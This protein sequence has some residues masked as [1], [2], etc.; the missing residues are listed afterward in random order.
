M[1][2]TELKGRYWTKESWNEWDVKRQLFDFLTQWDLQAVVYLSIAALVVRFIF[3]HHPSCVVFDEVHFGG[4]TRHY[5]K[6]EYFFDLHPPL[7]RLLVTLS[8]WAG[9][10]DGQFAFYAIGAD[11]IRGKAPYVV[12]RAFTA[13]FGAMVAPI[14]F[15]TLRG[16]NLSSHLSAAIAACVIFGTV[17]LGLICRK[18]V[19]DP[20]PA[21]T[22]GFLF[23]VLYD[24]HWLVLVTVSETPEAAI[25]SGLEAV[26]AGRGCEYGLG[27]QLQMGWIISGGWYWDFCHCG[28]LGHIWGR[29]QAIGTTIF[30]MY[31]PF[32]PSTLF[33]AQSI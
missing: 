32:L 10:F 13:F 31:R 7:A 27:C 24:T 1:L 18:C 28:A 20:K 3:L 16:F 4:F 5:L 15:V 33:T 26:P 6:H 12:M 2:L 29:F 19:D 11:Y 23:G 17:M 21:H 25:H 22:P 8:A 9:S 14:A 30:P